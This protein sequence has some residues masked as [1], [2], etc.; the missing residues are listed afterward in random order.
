MPFFSIVI[1]VYNTQDYLTECLE[2]VVNQTFSDFEVL[3]VDDGSTDNSFDI[4]QSYAI[5]DSRIRVIHQENQGLF[6]ARLTGIRNA[7]GKYYIGLDSDDYITIDC[8]KKVY[9]AIAYSQADIVNWNLQCFGESEEIIRC[10]LVPNYIYDSKQFLLNMIWTTNHSMCN[11]AIAFSCFEIESYEALGSGI[12]MSEDYALSAPAIARANTVYVLDETLYMYRKV[13]NSISYRG[14]LQMVKD[15][16]RVSEFVQERMLELDILSEDILKADFS[17]FLV[18]IWS[19]IWNAF[20]K[21]NFDEGLSHWIHDNSYY[22]KSRKYETGATLKGLG[23]LVLHLF[24]SENYTALR[25]IARIIRFFRGNK[26]AG[27]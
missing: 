13:G 10:R 20:L 14:D 16:I 8:L 22:Q 1:P 19:R 7:V 26:I 23:L 18:I 11:K 4:I 9:E 12:Q 21:D 5:I 2:S 24:R 6:R 25:L 27:I 17:M 3:I 15:E